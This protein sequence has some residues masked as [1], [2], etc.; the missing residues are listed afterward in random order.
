MV[1]SITQNAEEKGVCQ[2]VGFRVSNTHKKISLSFSFF[3]SSL[4]FFCVFWQEEEC[5]HPF[6]PLLLLLLL[7][8]EYK[9]RVYL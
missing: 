1:S 4:S 8:E 5:E 2:H 9:K 6:F 7:L 3:F